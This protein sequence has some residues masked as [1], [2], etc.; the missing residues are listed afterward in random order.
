ML[1]KGIHSFGAIFRS[2]RALEHLFGTEEQVELWLLSLP[3]LFLGVWGWGL[4][5]GS[6]LTGSQVKGK[7]QAWPPVSLGL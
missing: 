7:S 4:S 2:E 3:S 5:S 6:C 1:S